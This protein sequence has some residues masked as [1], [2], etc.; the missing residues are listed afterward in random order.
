MRPK[1]AGIDTPRWPLSQPPCACVPVCV[2][3]S[4]RVCV[5]G[6]HISLY[7][8][9]QI[10]CETAAAANKSAKQRLSS[11]FG[12]ASSAS[13]SVSIVAWH[14][15]C[16]CL[17]PP[18]TST[19]FLSC[20]HSCSIYYTSLCLSLSLKWTAFLLFSLPRAFL[21]RATHFS[22]DAADADVDCAA[23][24]TATASD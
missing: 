15:E 12:F 16:F 24:A 6:A 14:L 20:S 10:I 5:C 17:V 23:T 2:C 19:L 3:A 4:V 9:W 8:R 21:F 22:P 13:A 18:P 1:N 7:G 11:V